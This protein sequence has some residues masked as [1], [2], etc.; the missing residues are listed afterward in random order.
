MDSVD[1][2]WSN[3]MAFSLRHFR[4]VFSKRLPVVVKVTQGYCFPIE[5]MDFGVDEVRVYSEDLCLWMSTVADV[6][7]DCQVYIVVDIRKEPRVILQT[8]SGVRLSIPENF[9][10]MKFLVTTDHKKLLFPS[11]LTSIE[12]PDCVKGTPQTCT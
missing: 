3:S 2:V 12:R 7:C 1:F 5:E 4:D 10:D 8:G 9:C 6:C 11:K